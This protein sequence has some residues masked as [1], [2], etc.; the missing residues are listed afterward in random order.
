M[1]KRDARKPQPITE[2]MLVQNWVEELK[3]LVPAKQALLITI[4][5]FP[6]RLLARR[7]RIAPPKLEE[8]TLQSADD[9]RVGRVISHITELASFG[10]GAKRF[11]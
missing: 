7:G 1:V 8:V 4:L 10:G 6:G 3:R 9:L 5:V 2:T 11:W